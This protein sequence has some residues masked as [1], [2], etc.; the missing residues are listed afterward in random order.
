MGTPKKEIDKEYLFNPLMPTAASDLPEDLPAAPAPSAAARTP[1]PEGAGLSALGSGVKVRPARELM[2]VNLNERL[3][4]DRLDEVFE[5]FRCCR[6]DRCRQDVAAL[7][8]NALPAHYVVASPEEIPVLR[9][10]EG[11]SPGQE[12]P[13]ALNRHKKTAPCGAVFYYV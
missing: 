6:C 2:L 10:G 8:L 4:A 9:T 5:K 1:A 3:V 13:P 12:T 7:A 11:H